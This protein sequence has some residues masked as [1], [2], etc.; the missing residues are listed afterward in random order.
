MKKNNI[1]VKV[2]VVVFTLLA[3]VICV[4]NNYNDFRLFI[5]SIF[6]G[7]I[8]SVKKDDKPATVNKGNVS[9]D[10][11]SEDNEL[12]VTEDTSLFPEEREIVKSLFTNETAQMFIL[13]TATAYTLCGETTHYN[14]SELGL[15]YELNGYTKC[16]KYNTYNEFISQL[17]KYVTKDYFDNNSSM[18]HFLAYSISGGTTIDIFYNFYE[19][20]GSLYAYETGKGTNIFYVTLLDSTVYAVTSCDDSKI[21]AVVYAKWL[22]INKKEWMEKV[23]MVLVNDNGTWKINEYEQIDSTRK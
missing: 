9:K 16:S 6:S 4:Y 19:K 1:W 3:I 11:S 10:T 22:D 23:H 14:S 17:M 15:D 2:I 8:D 12:E 7:A 18:Q 21:D 20:D 13:N 5:N